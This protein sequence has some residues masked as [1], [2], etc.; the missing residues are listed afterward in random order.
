MRDDFLLYPGCV[1][2]SKLPYLEAAAVFILERLEVTASPFP[3]FSCCFEPVGLRSLGPETW[4]GA[5]GRLH[6]LAAGRPLLTLCDGCTLSLFESGRILSHE[7]TE[8][9]EVQGLMRELNRSLEQVSEV[10]GLLELLH[11]RLESIKRCM[12]K[13]Q[14]IRLLIHP[15]CHCEHICHEKG[16]SAVKM[17]EDIVLAL[18]GEPVT[19]SEGL[20][21]GGGLTSVNDALG[22]NIMEDA[23]DGMEALGAEAIITSC[24]FC[25]TQFDV[26]G[27]R[28]PVL[29]LAEL[30]AWALGWEVDSTSFHRTRL[31]PS[32]D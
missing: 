16:L 20:C 30:C 24:P 17:M 1:I 23:L 8:R 5:C 29:H 13:K 28:I 12:V 25:F 14:R 2:P 7:G 31:R 3:E 19:P 4:L 11:S 21:C 26:I 9:R 15:G 27:R 6:S 22:R 32:A 10:V 18:G